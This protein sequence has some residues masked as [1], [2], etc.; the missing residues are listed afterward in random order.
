MTTTTEIKETLELFADDI[1]NIKEKIE[2]FDIK[3]NGRIH[4]KSIFDLM[5]DLSTE[6]LELDYAADNTDILINRLTKRLN[7]LEQE[8]KAIKMIKEH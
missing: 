6:L 8:L 1:N 7:A 4:D 2:E 3:I 5:N